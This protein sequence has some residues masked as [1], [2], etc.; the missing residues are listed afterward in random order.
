MSNF[1]L[2]PTLPSLLLFFFFG[3][4]TMSLKCILGKGLSVLSM[5]TA[6]RKS[7]ESN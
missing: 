2:L 3:R 6:S 5:G 4:N 1:R 7:F